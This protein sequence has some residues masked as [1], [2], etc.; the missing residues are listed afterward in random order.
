MVL[1]IWVK[2][3]QNCELER[4]L[5]RVVHSLTRLIFYEMIESS[6]LSQKLK[7]TICTFDRVKNIRDDTAPRTS[8]RA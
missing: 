8:H 7:G 3:Y 6:K 4:S 5:Q 2:S 1:N